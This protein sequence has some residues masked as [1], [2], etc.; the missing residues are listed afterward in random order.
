MRT[1]CALTSALFLVVAPAS[2]Q[3]GAPAPSLKLEL[4][5]V[6]PSDKGCR[7]TFVVTNGLAGYLQKVGFELALFDMS[8]AVDRLTALAFKDMPKGKTKV[9]RF[10]LAGVDCTSLGRVLVNEATECAGAGV[11]PADCMKRLETSSRTDVE[12]G[13]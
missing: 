13:I 11:D 10:D 4:N 3:E 12:L 6:Q 5:A 2:A 9:S 1:A 8:G 7:L